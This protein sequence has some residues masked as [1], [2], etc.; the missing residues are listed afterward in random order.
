[1]ENIKQ[2]S[3]EEL[4]S[5]FDKHI[6]PSSLHRSVLSVHVKSQIENNLPNS[7]DQLVA[8]VRL[9]IVDE[10]YDIPP[11]EVADAVNGDF[12]SIPDRISSLLLKHGYDR[13]RVAQ[14]L[15]KS[16]KV[17]NAQTATNTGTTEST[18]NV[19]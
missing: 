7:A 9:F 1:M 2:I 3:K 13:D 6:H 10:G 8:D 14:S 5:F 12:S 15:A 16:T 4:L 11:S 19:L 17:F 18:S